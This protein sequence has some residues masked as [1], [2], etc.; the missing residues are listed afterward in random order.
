MGGRIATH[1]AAD[2]PSLAITGL[3]LLGYPL[4][5]PDRPQERRDA[6]LPSISR[7]VLFYQGTRDAFGRPEEIE[8]ILPKLRNATLRPVE[9]GDHS[10]KLSRRN[11]PAQAALHAQI[12]Q[13][14]V[15]WML[16]TLAAHRAAA[17]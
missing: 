2:D 13:G 4:H 8:E 5:P 1:V 3:V 6:H 15:Q 16:K 7:P 14:I 17:S 12:Q 10:F 11:P 9:N